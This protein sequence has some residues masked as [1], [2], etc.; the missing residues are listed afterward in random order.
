MKTKALAIA[1]LTIITLF[2]SCEKNT[3]QNPEIAL[4]QISAQP[5]AEKKNSS[6]VCNSS[7]RP[8]FK[9]I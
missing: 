6:I 9:T 7:K 2:T 3:P 1:A 4:T 5:I 8:F